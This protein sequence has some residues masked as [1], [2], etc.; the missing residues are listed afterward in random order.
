M[1]G[2]C[3]TFGKPEFLKSVDFELAHGEVHALV[4]GNGARKVYG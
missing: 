3:K 2:I 4:G 1:E